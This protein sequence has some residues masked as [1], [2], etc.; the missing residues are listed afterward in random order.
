MNNLRNEL[1]R[2][3]SQIPNELITDLSLS[4]GALRV[5]LYL[6]TKPDEWS[7]YN[8]DICKQLDICEDT[9]SKYWKE[10]LASKWLKREP[11]RSETGTLS[12]GYIYRIG[13]FTVSGNFPYQEETPTIN[14]TKPL[15]NTKPLS[16]TKKE[17]LP[18]PD[19]LNA[20]S[21]AEWISYRK[22]RKLTCTATTLN[23][24]IEDLIAWHIKGHSMDKI[25]KASITA[26]WQGLFEPKGKLDKPKSDVSDRNNINAKF[27]GMPDGEIKF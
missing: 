19:F 10:L 20:E 6:F 9:L 1:K 16:K 25:I 23:A 5:L 18:L 3:Y 22:E 2:S 4:S 8:A 14:K 13:E 7:V 17:I 12:G 11:K 15:S 21:W 26:G 27:E 24:Q